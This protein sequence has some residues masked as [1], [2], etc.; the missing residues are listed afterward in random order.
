MGKCRFQSCAGADGEKVSPAILV[1]ACAMSRRRLLATASS[2]GAGG[3][4][5][6][7]SGVER[8]Q[9]GWS[10]L[11]A[12]ATESAKPF[13]CPCSSIHRQLQFASV[14]AHRLVP[15]AH[16]WLARL[17]CGAGVRNLHR[18][19]RSS[20]LWSITSEEGVRESLHCKGTNK[21]RN[22]CVE[23]KWCVCVGSLPWC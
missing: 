19:I 2:V 4:G 8:Q 18:C 3:G 20:L 16:S 11:V 17:D 13:S 14:R 10:C 21:D 6:V 23:D 22:H 12:C 15:E 5:E 1:C 7:D 9:D